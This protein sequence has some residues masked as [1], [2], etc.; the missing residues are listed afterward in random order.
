M[1]A[2]PIGNAF[3]CSV[4]VVGTPGTLELRMRHSVVGEAPLVPGSKSWNDAETAAPAWLTVNVWPA[5]VTVPVRGCP[6]LSGIAMKTLPLPVPEPPDKIVMNDEVVVAVHGQ[7]GPVVTAIVA[8]ALVLLMLSV[9]G[10]SE[11]EQD[12]GVRNVSVDE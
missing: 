12:V 6:G 4:H 5:M 2:V 3:D 7:L 8:V 10:A 11:Y 9:V 1:D